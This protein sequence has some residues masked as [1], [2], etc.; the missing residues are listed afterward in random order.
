M[1]EKKQT[2][3]NPP[4][5]CSN[6]KQDGYS[7]CILVLKERCEKKISLV[8]LKTLYIISLGNTSTSLKK[9]V[10]ITERNLVDFKYT[11]I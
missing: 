7:N 1:K 8:A 9:E 3:R 4:N 6:S 10:N 11:F 5:S 2:P